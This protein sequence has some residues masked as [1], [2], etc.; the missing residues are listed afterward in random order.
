MPDD[1]EVDDGRERGEPWAVPS[2]RVFDAAEAER[3]PHVRVA[4]TVAFDE[5]RRTNM[6]RAACPHVGGGTA[7][8]CAH[9]WERGL[10][11]D[12]CFVGVHL[13]EDGSVPC[14]ACES[15][16]SSEPWTLDLVVPEV[17][18]GFPNRIRLMGSVCR[19]HGGGGVWIVSNDD[20]PTV[21]DTRWN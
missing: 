16:R 14:P 8:I 3:F 1:D 7:Y 18:D 13:L 12:R 5:L 20:T 21:G 6:M 19:L 4:A 10:W 9:H 15:R 2:V 11:C 17:V